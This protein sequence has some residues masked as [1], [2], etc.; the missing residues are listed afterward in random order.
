MLEVGLCSN[1]T[2]R[3]I[4]PEIRGQ[5]AISSSSLRTAGETGDFRATGLAL[6]LE[7]ESQGPLK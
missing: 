3:C 4:T 2:H 7:A 1:I 6:C 5:T